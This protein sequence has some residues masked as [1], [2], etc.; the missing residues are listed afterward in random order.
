MTKIRR[1][2]T[3]SRTRWTR[4]LLEWFASILGK[5]YRQEWAVVL[6]LVLGVS[7]SPR[8]QPSTTTQVNT[9]VRD[10]IIV[11]RDT[12]TYQIPVEA[13]SSYNVQS[14]HLETSVAWSVAQIDS[15]GVL[16][17]TLTNKPIEVK[18]EFIYVDRVV[19]EYKDSIVTKEVPVPVEVPVRYVPKMYKW[20]L[21]WSIV[22]V[23][24]LALWLYCKFR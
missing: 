11:H 17:H 5:M 22:S 9:I 21:V 12:I 20:C 7:C 6:L 8:L 13:T 24:L 1:F 2:Q 3:L 18:K 15:A 14:S 23:L 10:S 19:T 4:L 16:S